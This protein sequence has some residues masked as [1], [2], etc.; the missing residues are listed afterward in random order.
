MDILDRT[1]VVQKIPGTGLI[2]GIQYDTGTSNVII[3]YYRLRFINT[4]T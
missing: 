2:D 3:V 4:K 1:T